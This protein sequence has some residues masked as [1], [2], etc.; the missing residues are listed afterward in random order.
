MKRVEST[1]SKL[2]AT[3]A[4]AAVGFLPAVSL[5]HSIVIETGHTGAQ[6][7]IDVGHTSWWSFSV[8]SAG[9]YDV[10]GYLTIKDGP[11]TT[12]NVYLGL[13]SG[14]VSAPPASGVYSAGAWP[15]AGLTYLASA[16]VTHSQ[17][18]GSFFQYGLTPATDIFSFTT[19]TLAAGNYTLALYSSAI[20]AQSQAYFIKGGTADAT[21]TVSEGAPVG[22]AAVDVPVPGSLALLS[23]GLGTLGLA[24]RRRA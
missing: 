11:S 13:F 21:I 22:P 2:T 19:P 10:H 12:E 20:D 5:A 18:T 4:L 23:L 6:T 8:G 1:F 9:V 7:Q 17:V 15:A 14:V 24:L 16:T 3:I